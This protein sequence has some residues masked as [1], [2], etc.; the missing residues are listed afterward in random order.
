MFVF[1]KN[2]LMYIVYNNNILILIYLDS[3]IK[4][5]FEFF[6][7]EKRSRER[8]MK[9]YFSQILMFFNITLL[10]FMITRGTR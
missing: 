8:G 5:D 4:G 7:R 1:Q 3:G 2:Y 10:F 6:A 9:E